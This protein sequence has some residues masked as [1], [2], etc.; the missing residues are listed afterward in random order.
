MLQKGFL[1]ENRNTQEK[2]SKRAFIMWGGAVCFVIGVSIIMLVDFLIKTEAHQKQI[3]EF[4]GLSLMGVGAI[5]MCIGLWK[6]VMA[7]NKSRRQRIKVK[8]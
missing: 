4:V 3:G 7:Q 2:N 6:N 5:L 8:R 1:M